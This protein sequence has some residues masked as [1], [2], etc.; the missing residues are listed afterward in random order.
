MYNW[1]DLFKQGNLYSDGLTNHLKHTLRPTVHETLC[2]MPK[3]EM[4]NNIWSVSS[5]KIGIY[6]VYGSVKIGT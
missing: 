1:E 4:D 5:N 3:T 6:T 2:Q